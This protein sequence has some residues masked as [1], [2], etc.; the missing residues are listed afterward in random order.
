[1]ETYQKIAKWLAE[2]ERGISS[3]AIAITTLGHDVT[4]NNASTPRDPADLR[5]CIQLLEQ[6]PEARKG[7]EKLAA[8]H[9]HW[10]ILVVHWD[11]LEVALRAEIGDD[12]EVPSSAPV[13]YSL[14]KYL[15]GKVPT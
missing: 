3:E 15:D 13:T 9:I 12:L 6:V 2:G 8:Q 10:T 7:L 1:M 5:R 11:I 4:G 14:M